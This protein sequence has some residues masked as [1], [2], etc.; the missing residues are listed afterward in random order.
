MMRYIRLAALL[1]FLLAAIILTWVNTTAVPLNYVIGEVEVPLPVA[2]WAGIFIGAM[3]GL[4][5][6]LGAY[7]RVRKENGRLRRAVKLAETE[8]NN[9]RNLPIKDAR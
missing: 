3:L 1:L 6:A 2:L 5:A 4:I 9:L 7:L 8:V